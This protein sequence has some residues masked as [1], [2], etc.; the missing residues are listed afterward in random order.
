MNCQEAQPLLDAWFDGELD[1]ASSLAMERHLETCAECSGRHRALAALREEI[2]VADLDFAT[3]AILER[4]RP[5]ATRYAPK[6]LWRLPA[7]LAAAAAL[8]LALMIPAGR[9][10]ADRELLDSHLR[11]LLA[12]HLIDTPSSDRHT[13]KPWFQGRL[14]FAPPVPDLTAEGFPLAG[15]RID[16]IGSRKVAALVYQRREHVINLWISPGSDAPG[17]PERREIDGYHLLRWAKAG[18][19]Y[20]AV[21]DVEADELERFAGAVRAR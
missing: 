12:G 18:M 13:V 11:S 20:R 2:A 8:V 1:L 16:V 4:L 7:I 5:K 21:S 3:E 14:D 10:S 6:N 9:D 19:T 17:K 15:G